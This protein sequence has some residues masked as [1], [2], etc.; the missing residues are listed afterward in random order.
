MKKISIFV[1]AVLFVA[2]ASVVMARPYMGAGR[3][4]ERGGRASAFQKMDL[5]DDQT[6]KINALRESLQKET[7]PLRTDLLKK[8]TEMKL[9]W[10]ADEPDAGKI[11]ALQK[12][13][14]DLRGKMADKFT[15]YRLAV[16]KILTPEQ[17]AQSLARRSG[18]R[19]ISRR[20]LSG[21]PGR[22]IGAAPRW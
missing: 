5:T 6:E 14:L 15:D 9:L 7:A 12:E 13:I 1:L 20:G 19:G 3:G 10:M 2:T 4:M 17:R 11:K 22:G 16:H 21:P 18:K 8:S